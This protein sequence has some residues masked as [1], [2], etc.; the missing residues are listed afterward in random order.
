V[1][2]LDRCALTIPC[3]NLGEPPV[4]L[5]LIGRRLED[6]SL[7]SIGLAVEKAL[8]VSNFT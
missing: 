7:F 1:N 4:G 5:M 8:H 3:H 6:K 2:F